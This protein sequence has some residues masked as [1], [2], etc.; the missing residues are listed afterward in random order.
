MKLLDIGNTVERAARSAA[1]TGATF[2]T[3]HGHDRKT[4]AAA[5]AGSAGTR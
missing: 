1:A 3:V 4:L 5:L 2:L